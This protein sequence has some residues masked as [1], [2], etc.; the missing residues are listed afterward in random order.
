MQSKWDIYPGGH[1][2]DQGIASISG[3]RQLSDLSESALLL[4]M[5]RPKL[6][7]IGI[8]VPPR[9]SWLHQEAQGALYE[10]VALRVKPGQTLHGS[11]NALR[12]EIISFAR[13]YGGVNQRRR[14]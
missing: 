7:Q 9:P 3:A 6:I 10:A 1:H 8:P 13:A 12:N 2:I 14:R 11:F 5:A 4:L